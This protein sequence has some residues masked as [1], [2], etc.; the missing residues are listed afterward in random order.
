MKKLISK[1]HNEIVKAC[2]PIEPFP[3]YMLMVIA[4]IYGGFQ[5]FKY[6]L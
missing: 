5:I 1:F 6:I 4:A 2:Y 3:V